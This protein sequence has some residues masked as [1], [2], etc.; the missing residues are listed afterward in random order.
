[1]ILTD[2][3]FAGQHIDPETGL[4]YLRARYYDPATGQFLTLDPIET[5]TRE[6][7]GYAHN[8]PLNATD[9]SGLG[10]CGRSWTSPGDWVDCAADAGRKV[11]ET[12][13]DAVAATPPGQ[14]LSAVSQVT[15]LTLGPCINGSLFGGYALD[16]SVCYQA[17]PNGDSGFTVTG[18]GGLGVPFG[19]AP[20]GSFQFSNAQSL[21]DL[22]G[23]F[24]Y[25][26]GWIQ[27]GEGPT[28]GATGAFGSSA[29]GDP[30]WA[31]DFGVGIAGTM[32]P[33]PHGYTGGRS[34]TWAF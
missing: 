2:A 31:A 15:G 1:M 9:P 25:G 20:S 32:P 10:E 30:I 22:G 6:P 8:N 5:L 14:A 11:V 28:V 29:C 7:Y 19:A 18:G 26:S 34:Y 33:I 27:P 13:G 12:T 4:Q 16:G 3:A 23:W 21:D 17:A 24:T